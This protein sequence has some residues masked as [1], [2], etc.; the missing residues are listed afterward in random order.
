[1]VKAYLV[2][3]TRYL[4]GVDAN[5]TLP[6]NNQGFGEINLG[7]AFDGIPRAAVDQS[8]IFDS[9]GQVYQI[10]GV[11]VDSAHPFRVTLA[12]TDAP[13][14][15]V[16]A[17]YVN[18]LD[19]AV[20]VGGQT[21]LGNHFD[22]A[23][24]VAGGSADPRNNVESVFLPAGTSGVFTIVITATN[25]AGNGI[26]GNADPTDQDFALM[27]YNT[28]QTVGTLQGVTTVSGSGAPIVGATIRA[29]SAE[30]IGITT[31][32]AG[33]AYRMSLVPDVYTVTASAYGYQPVVVSNITVTKDMT[34]TQNLALSP[35]VF[36]RVSGT[37]R[38][39]VTGRP[40][41]A[42]IRITGYPGADV[43]TNPATGFYSVSL[44]ANMDYVFHISAGVDG[45]SGVTRTVGPLVADR[46]EDFELAPDLV[47]CSAPGYELDGWH[48]GF[49]AVTAPL[50]PTGWMATVVTATDTVAIWQT[51]DQTVHPGGAAP[52]SAPNLVYFNSYNVEW[53]GASRLYRTTGLDLTSLPTTT[54]SFWMVHD[55]S[56]AGAADQMQVQV[57]TDS[58]ASWEDVG[59]P[60]ARYDGSTGW[61]QHQVDLSAYAGQADL[62]LGLLGISEYGNDVHVDDLAMA[63]CRSSA[64][65]TPTPTP[66]STPTATPTPTSTPTAGE[67]F[68]LPLIKR[69]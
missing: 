21:Y 53:G 62:R 2:N 38:D 34:T 32:G 36:H 26:P 51:S 65:A 12:W 63:V 6:S 69:S 54:L 17:A 58:G 61:K 46:T 47:A 68:Y 55:M 4:T 45:Y 60:V 16:G 28:A 67:R 48:E 10:M 31:S 33:G 24:V 66:T 18:D 15:T 1:M 59:A 3:A 8:H 57:S 29:N 7:V 20:T 39:V 40:L 41:S 37:V 52:H 14:P 30:G 44:A 64:P 13:G 22:G 5:D 43:W 27:V 23:T 25:I 50:L 56:Y 9:S 49:D 11:I 35:T 19:L 42:L